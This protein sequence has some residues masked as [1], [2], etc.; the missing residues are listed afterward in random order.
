M[1]VCSGCGKPAGDIVARQE[2]E[3]RDQPCFG[4]LTTVV[5]E[6]CRLR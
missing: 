5:V 2:R 6:L 4:Y 3:V 1:L